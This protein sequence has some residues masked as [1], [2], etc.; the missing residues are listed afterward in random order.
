MQM[1]SNL[2]LLVVYVPAS[3]A[4]EIRTALASAHAGHIGNYDSCSFSTTGT[5]RFRGNEQSN[6]AI[7][8]PG[9]LEEVE[10]ERIEAVVTKQHL[11]EAVNAILDSHPYEQ[12]AIHI[13]PMIDYTTL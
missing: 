12:P 10:E 1:E 5:G 7:G 8:S 9:T 11:K 3:H 2:S 6:P 4:D 13:L